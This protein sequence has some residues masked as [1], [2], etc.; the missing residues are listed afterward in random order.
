M[1]SINTEPNEPASTGPHLHFTPPR[2][3]TMRLQTMILPTTVDDADE[4]VLVIDQAPP[5]FFD[6]VSEGFPDVLADK[7]GAKAC[8]IFRQEVEVS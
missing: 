2:R 5:E 7:L 1:G 3:P 6:Q 4:W 8:L